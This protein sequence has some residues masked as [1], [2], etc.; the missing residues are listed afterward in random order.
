MWSLSLPLETRALPNGDEVAVRST[1]VVIRLRLSDE[2]DEEDEEGEE[3]GDA[4]GGRW[5]RGGGAAI[6]R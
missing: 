1:A 2:E 3:G 6:E 4:A 5:W